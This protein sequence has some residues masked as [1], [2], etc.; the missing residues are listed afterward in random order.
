MRTS[1]SARTGTA[2]SAAAVGVGARTSAAKSIKVTSVSWPTAEIS[3]IMLA[4]AART[5]ISSL[6]DHR[7]S[8]EP[9]PRATMIRWG[10]NGTRA[11]SALKPLMAAAT[12]SAEPSPCTRTGHTTTWR[13]KRA[14]SRCKMSRMTAPVGEVT[15]PITSGR[16]GS[17]CLRAGSNRP[18]AA[19]FFLR[20]S[21]SAI[22]APIPAGSS[23]STTIW[24]FDWPG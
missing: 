15:T 2:I 24:Y 23:D 20:S 16:N 21:T 9:P 4:A 13:G 7:S 11:G 19:S 1:S 3:G 6:N 10:L 8:S 14:A 12:S 5:T 17:S 22:S 18:S